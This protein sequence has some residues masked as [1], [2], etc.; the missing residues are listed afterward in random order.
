MTDIKQVIRE[1]IEA[2]KTAKAYIDHKQP[3]EGEDY[4]SHAIKSLQRALE[5]LEAEGEDG[6]LHIAYMHGAAS[7][8]EK[9]EEPAKVTDVEKAIKALRDLLQETTHDHCV[10][11]GV[12]ITSEGYNIEHELR[13]PGSLKRDG[14]SMRNIKGEFIE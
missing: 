2:L 10:H 4:M 3:V 11:V 1:G 14:V 6:A 13:S 7:V 12:S 8:R 5:Q 9:L